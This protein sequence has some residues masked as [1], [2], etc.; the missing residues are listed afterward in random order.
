[1]DTTHTP[2]K[3]TTIRWD[4]RVK[5]IAEK[6]RPLI[7]RNEREEREERARVLARELHTA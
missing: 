7:E 3:E 6:L 5:A 2:K 4:N 1:M